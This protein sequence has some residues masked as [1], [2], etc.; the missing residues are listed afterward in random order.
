MTSEELQSLLHAVPFVP[1][2][3]CRDE[4]DVDVPDRDWV[5]HRPGARRAV[6]WTPDDTLMMI[7]LD[8]AYAETLAEIERQDA[9]DVAAARDGRAQFRRGECVPWEQVK[10]E[11]G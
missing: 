5:A 11:L 1:F 7:D 10:A 8:H 4:G 2:V 3:F 6:V 9:D